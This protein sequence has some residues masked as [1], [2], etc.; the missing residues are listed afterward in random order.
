MG[1]PIFPSEM[2]VNNTVQ[3]YGKGISPLQMDVASWERRYP[4]IVQRK[5]FYV[6]SDGDFIDTNFPRRTVLFGPSVQT[7]NLPL[8]QVP[9]DYYELQ[10]NT[11][12]DI[13]IQAQN[14]T[15][16]PTTFILSQGT[17]GNIRFDGSFWE[18]TP[19]NIFTLKA[20]IDDE[21]ATITGTNPEHIQNIAE[22]ISDA[23]DLIV[24][25]NEDIDDLQ[26][27]FNQAR[28]DIDEIM[29]NI[30]TLN[31]LEVASNGNA[32]G[33]REASARDLKTVLNLTTSNEVFA[34]LRD[35][36]NGVNT[37]DFSGLRIGDYID[38]AS[39]ND[40]TTN[41]TWNDTYKNLRLVIAGFNTYHNFGDTQNTKNH[42]LFMFR[43]VI[44]QKQ[45]KTTNDNAGGFPNTPL[46][47][48]LTGVFKTGLV[49]AMSGV[50]YIYPI[51]TYHST[52][53][54]AALGTQT[55]FLPSE[56]EVFGYQTYGDEADRFNTNVQF[57]IFQDSGEYRI[58]YY[59]GAR[60]WWWESTPWADGATHFCYVNG[61]GAT[62]GTY[63]SDANGGVSP[64]FALS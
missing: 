61:Y 16:T 53:G 41:F 20:Y 49:A 42:I 59:N 14:D 18:F 26:H 4:D 33:Y 47:V 54:G 62:G 48:Y 29:E 45:I 22:A 57:P 64:C 27:G 10:N 37:P 9:G 6:K 3:G 36:C 13:T 8:G 40:G 43:N 55:V 52:K 12:N 58:K 24:M 15:P 51:R 56:I 46:D 50:D 30:S 63:A 5:P 38:L 19:Y 7:V 21:V 32:P 31:N 44:T 39:L 28:V 35:R 34:T 2:Y 17:T 11:E 23:N 25:A 60:A 1:I